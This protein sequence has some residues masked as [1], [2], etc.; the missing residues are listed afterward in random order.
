MFIFRCKGI[1]ISCS[2]QI[3]GQINVLSLHILSPYVHEKDENQVIFSLFLDGKG[4][5]LRWF[6]LV[7]QQIFVIL[8]M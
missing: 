7:A 6:F 1:N 4:V 3:F 5:F 8:R 2:K